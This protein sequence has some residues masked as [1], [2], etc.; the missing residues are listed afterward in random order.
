MDLIHRKRAEYNAT[1]YRK[2]MYTEDIIYTMCQ[3]TN[4][5]VLSDRLLLYTK[6]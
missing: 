3:H 4:M 1:G 6:G 2:A 5:I